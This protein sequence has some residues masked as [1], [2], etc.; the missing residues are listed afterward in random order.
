MKIDT[1]DMPSGYSMSAVMTLA[2]IYDA[3]KKQPRPTD[4]AAACG[5]STAAV[6][7]ILDRL[8]SEGLVQRLPSPEDRRS[9]NLYLTDKGTRFC[10]SIDAR[11]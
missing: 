11:H 5:I 2:A 4:I 9:F 10:K 3:K 1:K 8:E 6:T 7:G